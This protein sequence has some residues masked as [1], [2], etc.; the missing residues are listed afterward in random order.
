MI[1]GIGIPRTHKR[2]GRMYIPPVSQTA[3]LFRCSDQKFVRGGRGHL[4][5]DFD[6]RVV[7]LETR[8]LVA[9]RAVAVLARLRLVRRPGFAKPL[10]T[11]RADFAALPIKSP[12]S[13]SIAFAVFVSGRSTLFF[14]RI[15]RL[16]TESCW[17]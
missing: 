12:A 1:T 8:F 5:R 6:L 17:Y 16:P 13:P 4:V 15:L 7:L 10:A 11:A 2:I 9:I 14:L 3:S